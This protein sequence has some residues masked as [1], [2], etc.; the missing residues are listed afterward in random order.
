MIGAHPN[1]FKRESQEQPIV[2]C[3]WKIFLK[4]PQSHYLHTELFMKKLYLNFINSVHGLRFVT[5]EH[6]FKVELF[7]LF[8]GIVS[9]IFIERPGITK[10]IAICM[11][12][13][14]MAFEALNTCIELLCDRLTL[15]IDKNI[16][17][18]KDIASAAVFLSVVSTAVYW[19]WLILFF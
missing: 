12:L 2:A 3:T 9:L 11:I 8:A 5:E 1:I 7:L 18:I 13:L 14:I 17:R 16:G 4:R 15:S 6:S 19:G 10:A